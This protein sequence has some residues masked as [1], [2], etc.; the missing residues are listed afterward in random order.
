MSSVSLIS[1]PRNEPVLSHAPGT[2]ERAQ[3]KAAL[4]DA[5]KAGVEL[6]LMIDG[7]A[8]RTDDEFEVRAPHDHG[9]VLAKGYFANEQHVSRAVDAALKRD[10]A[11]DR[12]RG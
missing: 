11:A 6:P 8:V 7:E 2:P 12:A 1:E 3:L 4:A 5:G 9:R 10:N